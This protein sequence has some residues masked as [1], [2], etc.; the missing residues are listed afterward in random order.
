MVTNFG[1]RVQFL[2]PQFGVGEILGGLPP[3]V[4]LTPPEVGFRFLLHFCF[5]PTFGVQGGEQKFPK[6]MKKSGGVKTKRGDIVCG[7][8]HAESGFHITPKRAGWD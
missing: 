2:S 5:P 1:Q 4:F 6:E 3:G 8:H 7:G